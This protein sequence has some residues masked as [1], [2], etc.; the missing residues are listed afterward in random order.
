MQN[1]KD[2]FI[3]QLCTILTLEA[4]FAQFLPAFIRATPYREIQQ[5]FRYHLSETHERINNLKHCFRLL[6]FEPAQSSGSRFFKLRK[7][8]Q[9]L[10][11]TRSSPRSLLLFQLH[12][13]AQVKEEG[14]SAYHLLIQQARSLQEM[15][16]VELLRRNLSQ[17]EAMS[18]LLSSLLAQIN[19]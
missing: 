14:I 12:Q 15:A 4:Q 13:T 10:L 11:K 18:E 19:I 3:P 1:M 9:Q 8:H 6:R 7:E 16:C 17:E 5:T 2:I